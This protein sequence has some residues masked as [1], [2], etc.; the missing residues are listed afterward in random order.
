M[1]DTDVSARSSNTKVIR[2]SKTRGGQTDADKRERHKI[3][4]NIGVSHN[5][6]FQPV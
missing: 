5:D 4:F 1:L 6:P 2:T 3:G